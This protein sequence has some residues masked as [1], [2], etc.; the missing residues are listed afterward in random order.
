MFERLRQKRQGRHVF[1]YAF[2]LLAFEDFDL[3]KAA[4]TDVVAVATAGQTQAVSFNQRVPL[5]MP[6]DEYRY[7]REQTPF[8]RIGYSI[9][10]Y[11]HRKKKS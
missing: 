9:Y 2:D 4:Y 3:T 10:I 8:T 7:W 11:D 6:R 5:Y 1:L